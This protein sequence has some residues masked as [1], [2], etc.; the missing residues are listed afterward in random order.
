MTSA[1]VPA[2]PRREAGAAGEATDQQRRTTRHGQLRHSQQRR[3]RAPCQ[4]RRRRGESV[5]SRSS[6]TREAFSSVT[7]AATAL[8]NPTSAAKRAT[9][10]TARDALIA[11][12]RGVGSSTSIGSGCGARAVERLRPVSPRARK[13]VSAPG[14]HGILDDAHRR[15][16]TA[17]AFDQ[18]RAVDQARRPRGRRLRHARL[19]RT[20]AKRCRVGCGAGR[21]GPRDAARAP[22]HR[23]ARRPARHRR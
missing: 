15:A 6:T 4:V 12:R 20:F 22:S 1:T 2:A 14:G 11:P 5:V 8:P 10:P 13:R 9:A 23:N 3:C 16:R 17:N 18:P 21:R 7:L 19:P